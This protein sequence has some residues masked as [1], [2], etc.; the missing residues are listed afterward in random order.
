M[1]ISE[2]RLIGAK[3][4]SVITCPSGAMVAQQ[5]SNL[6][7]VG[8]IPTSGEIFIFFTMSYTERKSEH[9]RPLTSKRLSCELSIHASIFI[10]IITFENEWLAHANGKCKLELFLGTEQLKVPI[11][12]KADMKKV[13][14]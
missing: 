2:N 11:Q 9:S 8:S 6:K 3:A 7:V 4:S 10:D 5:T 14:L 13:T 1:R 12:S